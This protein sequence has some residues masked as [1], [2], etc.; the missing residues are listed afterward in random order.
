MPRRHTCW[1]ALATIACTTTG[2]ARSAWLQRSA[3]LRREMRSILTLPSERIDLAPTTHRTRLENGCR[4]KSI[5]YA[6]EPGSRVTAL[7]YI[8]SEKSPVPAIV[9]A[10]GHGGSKSCLYA[11][12]AGQLYANMGFACLVPDTIGEEERH[13]DGKM[14][15]RGH[16]MYHLGDQ[17]PEFV[18]ARLKRL[19][20][21]KIVWD[22]MRGIDYLETRP[23][24]DASRIGIVGYSLGGASATCVAML[25]DRIGAAVI[26][27]W[28]WRKRYAE[29]SKY[30]TRM[31]CAA[32]ME[33]M[34]FDEMNALLAPH[35]ATLFMHGDKDTVMDHD[36]GGAATVRELTA[37]VAGA[38]RILDAA[39]LPGTIE[40]EFQPDADHRPFFLSRRAVLWLHRHLAPRHGHQIPDKTTKFGQWVDAQGQQIE[41]LYNTE[42]RERG[43]GVVDIGAVWHHP[44]DL[45]CFPDRDKP[46]PE[47]TM[48]GWVDATVR[49][50]AGK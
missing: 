33:V 3:E 5:S 1:L 6:S 49:A 9:V 17:N 37:S 31:P 4:I 45:A 46:A 10:C 34:D 47:H 42:A 41:E 21:G 12:Y 19:V 8:P 28:S 30:C 23:D 14:G 20:L 40:V 38:N 2:C 24:V 29:M 25:D 13:H 50:N 39:W 18:R 27:G 36:E 32:F 7:L 22:L 43:L 48:R 16:D 26:C 35:A 44:H 15:A 11:Q